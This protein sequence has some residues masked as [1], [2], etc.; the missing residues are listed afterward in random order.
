MLRSAE[1]IR[2]GDV[3]AY[4]HDDNRGGTTCYAVVEKVCARKL[5][6][7][8]ERGTVGYKY[9][10]FFDCKTGHTWPFVNSD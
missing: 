10:H 4:F 1:G 8:D 7:R 9:P 6:V 2:V 3:L 5:R